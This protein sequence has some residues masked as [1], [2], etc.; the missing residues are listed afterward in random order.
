MPY[1][2]TATSM[3]TGEDGRVVETT[4]RQRYSGRDSDFVVTFTAEGTVIDRIEQVIVDDILYLRLSSG[5]HAD[6]GVWMLTGI[7][8]PRRRT[9]SCVDPGSV[10]AG[11]VEGAPH[12][13]DT[14]MA[15]EELVEGEGPVEGTMREDYWFGPSGR[16]VRFVRTFVPGEGH[17]AQGY[18]A[19]YTFSGF[20]EPND[21]IP[22]DVSHLGLV[23][24][25][26][27]GVS[28]D[29]T[30]AAY[31]ESVIA[32]T[33]SERIRIEVQ[34]VGPDE[35]ETSTGWWSRDNSFFGQYERIVKDGTQY[36]REAHEPGEPP[37]YGE[38]F[39]TKM[40]DLPW[41]LPPC[42]D[43]GAYDASSETPHL[44]THPTHL[45]HFYSEP[46]IVAEW[47][48]DEYGRP[49][50]SVWSWQEEGAPERSAMIISYGGW[51][52]E[53]AIEAPELGPGTEYGPGF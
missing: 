50:R 17:A 21:I 45:P 30:A 38:W 13:T 4:V 18:A 29:L 35:H 28:C 53:S 9:L 44:T 14:F 40:R 49:T 26:G 41:Y 10:P 51:G 16:L 52:F 2:E 34:H 20:G 32:H 47:W 31:S 8:E 33:P 11:G 42:L 37:A 3:G 36:F 1:D 23:A 5:P 48:G 7:S 19:E 24:V 25:K 43:P 39:V 15:T 46:D 27:E 22:P 12:Y 6:E